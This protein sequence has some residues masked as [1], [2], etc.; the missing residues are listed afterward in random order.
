MRGIR[1]RGRL[2]ITALREDRLLSFLELRKA[3]RDGAAIVVHRSNMIV[4]VGLEALAAL[5][6]AGYGTP[7]VGGTPFD[8]VTIRNVAVGYMRITDQVAP[9][10]PAEGDTALE[11][12]IRWTGHVQTGI[13]DS[14]LNVTYPSIGEVNFRTLIPA[15]D[16]IGYTLTEEGLFT[17]DGLKLIAHTTFSYEKTGAHGLQLD[18]TITIERV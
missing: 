14:L 5:L 12:T 3:I 17:L 7:T 15:G 2:L 4:N 9:T 10:D 8:P 11:G 18:H 16:L 6:G 13:G 1:I